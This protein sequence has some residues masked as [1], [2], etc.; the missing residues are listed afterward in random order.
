MLQVA[1]D[2]IS[3]TLQQGIPLYLCTAAKSGLSSSS[4]KQQQQVRYSSAQHQW[5]QLY[6]QVCMAVSGACWEPAYPLLSGGILLSPL[7]H[8]PYSGVYLLLWLSDPLLRIRCRLLSH[9]GNFWQHY[10]PII[11]QFITAAWKVL[12]VTILMHCFKPWVASI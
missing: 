12:M 8:L 5:F 6:G 3:Y 11:S 1:I 7:R 9:L 10:L 2:L 4:L